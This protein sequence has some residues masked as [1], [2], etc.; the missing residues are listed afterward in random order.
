MHPVDSRLDRSFGKSNFRDV[1]YMAYVTSN[2]VLASTTP[3]FSGEKDLTLHVIT[4]EQH[5][6]HLLLSRFLVCDGTL[7]HHYICNPPA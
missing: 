1:D 6:A 3:S 2:R 7:S 5:P 4:N